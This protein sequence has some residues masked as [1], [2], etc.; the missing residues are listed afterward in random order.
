MMQSSGKDIVGCVV[1]LFPRC[2]LFE[3]GC[4]TV[5]KMVTNYLISDKRLVHSSELGMYIIVKTSVCAE[6]SLKR[7]PFKTF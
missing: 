3:T 2:I 5:W 1:N 4:Q 7:G 6:N